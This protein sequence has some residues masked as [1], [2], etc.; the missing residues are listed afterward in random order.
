MH[1]RSVVASLGLTALAAGAPLLTAYRAEQRPEIDGVLDDACWQAACVSSHFLKANAPGLPE[2]Q[3][4]ARLA[5][6]N[7]KLYLGIEAFEG[8]LEPRLNML[9]RV[10][11]EKTGRDAPVFGEDCVEI[12]LQPGSDRYFHFASNSGTGTYEGVA[13]SADWDC[14]WQC[15]VMRQ[16][17]RYVVEAAIPFSALDA[18]PTGT[19]RVNFTRHRPHAR[20]YS[21]WSG[22]QGAFHQPELFGDLRFAE[23]GPHVG[24]V[25]LALNGQQCSAA[26]DVAGQVAERT[27]FELTVASGNIKKS[28]TSDGHGNKR[29]SVAVPTTD[30][31]N[32]LRVTYTL[33]DGATPVLVSAAIPYDIAAAS[34]V[35]A[36]SA[37][38]ARAVVFHNGKPLQLERGQ[39]ALRLEPGLNL[40]AVAAQAAGADPRL[41]PSIITSD[42]RKIAA[43]WLVS[44]RAEGDGW[45]TSYPR[46]WRRATVGPEG[47][48]SGSGQ[49]EA[50]LLAALDVGKP[51]PQVFP[52]TDTFHIPRGSRQLLKLY[53]RPLVDG[54][55]SDDYR[56]TVELP[57][58]LRF[59]AA[60]APEDGPARVTSDPDE[61]LLEGR[62]MRRHCVSYDLFPGGGMELSLRWGDSTGHTLAYQPSITAGGTF[63]WRRLSMK[64]TP[65]AGAVNVHPLII[66]WQKRGITG[67]FWV[68]NLVFRQ[69]DSDKNLL[70]MGSFDEPE[71]GTAWMLKAEGADGS[72]CVKIVA[73]PDG[74][75]RQQALWVD[76]MEPN[77]P[78][79]NV[80]VE[81]GKT[82]VVELDVRCQN[83]VSN[84][85]KPLCELLFEAPSAMAEGEY[86]L[87]SYYS[88]AKGTVTGLPQRSCVRVLPS[89]KNVRPKKARLCPCYYGPL[90]RHPEVAK[91]Y[92]ENCWASGIT[93][94]YGKI[95]NDVVPHLL[96]R[97]H[98][99]V[100]SI[101]YHPWSSPAGTRHLLDEDPSLQALGFDG[102][103][104]QHEFCPTWLLA[105]G[106]AVLAALEAWLLGVVNAAPYFG[107]NWD[108]EQPVIDPPTFC[109]CLR[110][111]TAFRAFARLS[112]DVELSAE[113]LLQTYPTE[114]TDFRCM[115]NAEMAGHI[116]RILG[117]AERPIE[118]SLYSGYQSRRTKEH[119]GV[120]WARMAPHLDLA[121]AGYGGDRGRIGDTID[122]LAGVPF[123]GGEM[124]YLSPL[125]DA[126]PAPRME[127]WRNRVLRQFVDSG[128]NGCLFWWLASMDGG[129]FYATSEAAEIIAKYEELFAL[130]QRCDAKVK[131]TGLEA[132]NWAAFEREGTTLVLLLNFSAKPVATTAQVG[133]RTFE[134]DLE[135]YGTAVV[136][137]E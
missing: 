5:W 85:S 87:L 92:A 75:D 137:A 132:R 48:W 80:A 89:L 71:W 124:W 74:V 17:D 4:R 133:P 95:G 112:N 120:D 58:E 50:Y 66:K 63:D 122:A 106:D 26:A 96:D 60:N 93:W 79:T 33:A 76:K 69:E 57:A 10:K 82:Y 127:L 34:A 42:G 59:I 83:L 125:D 3:T 115:Q 19:W 78:Q 9:H 126:R 99:V 109:T 38:N 28:A 40:L 114:W 97:G 30:S 121:I 73:K 107:A 55:P 72:K 62:T 128:G 102:K 88:S 37:A 27:H 39:A 31:L 35:F 21:T 103:R 67:T 61:F 64:V 135:P 110:C 49:R 46:G 47:V 129:A 22:L 15:A 52:K 113:I 65:P 101:G 105:E 51:M 123:M 43:H 119:Y 98:R 116:K 111:L 81:A 118:F 45:R 131:V 94:T 20:E 91:A 100:L 54:T 18:G 2:E 32:R 29:L 136:L 44:E 7:G 16:A 53:L 14:D 8:L 134:R 108:L 23:L 77:K 24:P 36:L 130:S 117:K 84:T 41:T 56:F 11:A 90:F 25:R 70:Q 1:I 13:A 12:F 68:D 86:P 104:R 6:D